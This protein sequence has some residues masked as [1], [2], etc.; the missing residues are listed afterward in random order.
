MTD[1]RKYV[2]R[3]QALIIWDDPQRHEDVA[4]VNRNKVDVPFQY[5]ESLFAALAVVKSMAWLSYRH[6][7]GMLIKTFGDRDSLRYTTICR[8]FRC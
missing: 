5:A 4:T 8:R 1:N 7:Q 3:G 6:L 2:K